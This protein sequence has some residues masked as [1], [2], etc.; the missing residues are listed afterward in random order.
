MRKTFGMNKHQ[1]AAH[2]P[3]EEKVCRAEVADLLAM[4]N[5]T[6]VADRLTAAQY[7]CP[8][9]IQ[10]RLPAVWEAILRMMEDEDK[11]VRFAAW[12]TWEDGGL[13]TEEALLNRME[14]IYRRERDPK[15]RKFA[16]TILGQVLLERRR[17]ETTRLH[18]AA[19]V[20]P[21]LRGK[22]DFCGDSGRPVQRA[23]DALIPTGGLPRAAWI[24]EACVAAQVVSRV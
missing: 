7:L 3:G 5:S 4:A 8:C 10:A 13:P 24:C 17:L 11:R 20:P 15:V 6:E 16:A 9:H 23:L 21:A 12:H 1:K 14:Q 18:L 22:C 19:K 2:R